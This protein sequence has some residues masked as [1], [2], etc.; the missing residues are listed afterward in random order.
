VVA[1]NNYQ[2]APAQNM[3]AM[4]IRTMSQ[5]FRPGYLDRL[6]R[7]GPM[8]SC[9]DYGWR[10]V[11]PAIAGRPMSSNLRTRIQIAPNLPQPRFERPA[12]FVGGGAST[13]RPNPLSLASC[14]RVA[15]Y[16]GATIGYVWGR[17][18][19]ARYSSGVMP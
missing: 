3:I 13:L 10:E 8:S 11:G 15:A 6:P 17:F 2:Q 9:S 7:I 12:F 4:I 18:H 16:S 5:T 19:L 1:N 14:E